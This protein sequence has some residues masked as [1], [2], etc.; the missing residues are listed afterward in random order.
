[1]ATKHA[2]SLNAVTVDRGTPA[3]GSFTISRLLDAPRELVYQAWVN[4]QHLAA[5]W[6]P[7]MFTNHSCT[8]D[9]RPGGE[10]HLVMRGP[11]GD[12]YP[13]GGTSSM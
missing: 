10:F 13:F 6:G 8:I 9:A 11:Q 3:D 5:W 4:P 12:E 1:M 2:N 7:K